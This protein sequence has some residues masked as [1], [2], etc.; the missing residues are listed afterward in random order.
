MNETLPVDGK[1]DGP[2]PTGDHRV[3]VPATSML[4]GSEK[5]PTAAV[6]LLNHAVQGAHH[7]VDQVADR[8]APMAQELG[9]RASA[10]ADAVHAK[11]AQLGAARD[12]WVE[13]LRATVRSQPLVAV[14]AAVALGAVIARFTRISR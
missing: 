6:K 5:A 11:T 7:A 9:E 12:E 10:A 3:Q 14:A 13:S 1:S 2:W 8:A 4:P